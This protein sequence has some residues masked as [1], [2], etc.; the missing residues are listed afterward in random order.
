MTDVPRGAAG[1]VW[2]DP[3]P[4]RS[5]PT[6][7]PVTASAIRRAA[8]FAAALVATL[9][10]H[11]AAGGVELMAVAPVVWAGMTGLC[12]F[13][14]AVRRP[15]RF[16]ARGPAQ[17]CA[18]LVAAQVALHV[19]MSWAPW[20]FGLTAHH[21]GAMLTAGAL[22][23]HGAAAVVLTVLLCAGERLLAAAVAVARILAPVARRRGHGRPGRVLALVSRIAPSR[24]VAGSWSSRGPPRAIVI[25]AG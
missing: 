19:L 9:V 8:T 18:C 11:L 20:A 2:R 1:L 6:M 5:R 17:T 15:A 24:G 23:A 16:R 3:A 4:V 12:T 25:P 13:A 10:A 22:V 21:H 7:N 14:A